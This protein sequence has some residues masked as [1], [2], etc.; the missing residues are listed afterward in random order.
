MV[1]SDWIGKKVGAEQWHVRLTGVVLFIAVLCW[2]AYGTP[3]CPGCNKN[4]F[5]S[6]LL[7]GHFG[8]WIK[9]EFEQKESVVC[10]KCNH[11]LY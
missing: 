6:S 5:W 10:P 4:M 11:K 2:Q 8:G 9:F 7:H 1:L 3:R